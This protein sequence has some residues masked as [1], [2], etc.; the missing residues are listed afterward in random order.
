[1]RS[2]VAE[3][4]YG[5]QTTPPAGNW[6][7]KDRPNSPRTTQAVSPGSAPAVTPESSFAPSTSYCSDVSMAR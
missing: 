1:M 5:I 2:P 3:N 4:T 7:V 6:V